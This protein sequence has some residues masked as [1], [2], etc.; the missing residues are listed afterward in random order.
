MLIEVGNWVCHRPMRDIDNWGNVWLT[1]R[2]IIDQ[3]KVQGFNVQVK[4]WL[5]AYS[6]TRI[7]Q[8]DE[9]RKTKQKKT[10]SN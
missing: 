7:K 8:K 10:M 6:I 1:H 3:R 4:N 5:S 2:R 9:K